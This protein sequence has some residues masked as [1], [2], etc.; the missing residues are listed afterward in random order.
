MRCDD[1]PRGFDLATTRIIG[2]PIE[3]RDGDQSF[4]V[5]YGTG[6]QQRSALTAVKAFMGGLE[7]EVLYAGPQGQYAGLDQL[8]IRIPPTL[9][10][11]G[12]I[13]VELELDGR[14]TNPVNI[15]VK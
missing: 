10:G 1:S 5:L 7:A 13:T 9:R 15:F 2:H 11:R 12:E 3:L 4:L 8:N 6:L 14:L